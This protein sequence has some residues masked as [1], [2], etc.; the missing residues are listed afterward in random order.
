MYNLVYFISAFIRQFLLPNPY[1]NFFNND[2]IAALFNITVG[3][4][5]LHKLSFNLTGMHYDKGDC[6]TFG[7]FSYLIWYCINT[8]IFIGV[9]SFIIN[10]YFLTLTLIIIYITLFVV[11]YKI[12][13]RTY[14]YY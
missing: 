5:I 1:I 7:S 11:L 2:A 10:P 3:G 9:S 13:N 12:A 6:P 14:H 4:V 8:A